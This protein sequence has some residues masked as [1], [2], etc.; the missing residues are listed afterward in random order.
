[1]TYNVT[2]NFQSDLFGDDT[3]KTKL[4]IA[5]MNKLNEMKDNGNEEEMNEYVIENF[6][7]EEMMVLE[8]LASVWMEIKG[9]LDNENNLTYN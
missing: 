2:V 9:E 7:D 4:F 5:K 8:K 3:N 1:M 6:D